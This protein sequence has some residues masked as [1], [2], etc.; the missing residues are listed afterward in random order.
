[1]PFRNLTLDELAHHIGMDVREVKRLAD[2]GVLPGQHVGGAWRFNRA[3]MLEWLQREMHHLEPEQIERLERA[4][5]DVKDEVFISPMLPTEGIELNLP[6][7][8]KASVIRELVN[9]AD[10]ANLLYDPPAMLAA[11]QDREEMCPTALPGG[12]AFPHPRRPLE[13][14]IGEPLLCLARVP[15]GIPFGAPDGQLTDLFVLVCAQDERHHLRTLA[16]LSLLFSSGVG[17]ALRGT[18]TPHE[19]LIVIQEFEQ[20]LLAERK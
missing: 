10:R 17:D 18:E 11:L 15:A 19:A 13:N 12:V 6:A 3:Q 9:L 14:A 20:R 2:R 16:R 5:S 1:M 7:R 8:S 4:M